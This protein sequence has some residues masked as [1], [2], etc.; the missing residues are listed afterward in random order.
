M[1][2]IQDYCSYF[3]HSPKKWKIP[4][5][6]PGGEIN[7]FGVGSGRASGI[8]ICQ[9]KHVKLPVV[10]NDCKNKEAA[11]NSFTITLNTFNVVIWNDSLFFSSF[12]FLNCLSFKK[13]TFI[14]QVTQ[15]Y[16][17]TIRTPVMLSYP[18]K[19]CFWLRVYF[20][21]V[22]S[23]LHYIFAVW[24]IK[25]RGN[26]IKTLCISYLLFISMTAVVLYFLKGL[27]LSQRADI[28]T[29]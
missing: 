18:T 8:K 29:S 1:Y 5:S 11:Y 15:S 13:C 23:I 10:V 25:G 26:L 16:A 20:W 3:T 19:A 17:L 6:S 24:V 2:R 21:A 9:V 7:P 22:E 12:F 4:G 14:T 27:I 28:F